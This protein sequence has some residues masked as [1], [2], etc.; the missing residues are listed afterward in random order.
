MTKSMSLEHNKSLNIEP[1][2][3]NKKVILSI[4]DDGPTDNIHPASFA[5]FPEEP[6]KIAIRWENRDVE[7]VDLSRVCKDI[8]R[9]KRS[10]TNFYSIESAAKES[11]KKPRRADKKKNKVLLSNDSYSSSKS[12]SDEDDN[13]ICPSS[14]SDSDEDDNDMCSSSKSDSRE[15]QKQL[16]SC[17]GS[18]RKNNKNYDEQSSSEEESSDESSNGGRK[19]DMDS[20]SSDDKSNTEAIEMR[21]CAR[22]GGFSVTNEQHMNK[23]NFDK[24]FRSVY[25]SMKEKEVDSEGM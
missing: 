20:V 6:S 18:L 14:K 10:A 17:K 22:M 1:F 24:Y 8:I 3:Q 19:L 5:Y 25:K 12:D 21:D 13:A 16:L 9:G 23:K 15:G 7:E 11:A 2:I 4:E